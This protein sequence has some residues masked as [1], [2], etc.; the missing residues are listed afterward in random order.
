M[1][2]FDVF[3]CQNFLATALRKMTSSA[4]EDL[5]D[6]HNVV[7]GNLQHKRSRTGSIA[8][9]RNLVKDFAE[10]LGTGLYIHIGVCTSMI[11]HVDV[12][13]MGQQTS[14]LRLFASVQ[15]DR[16]ETSTVFAQLDNTQTQLTFDNDTDY[17]TPDGVPNRIALWR[18]CVLA[19]LICHRG[20]FLL[21]C[22]VSYPFR[23]RL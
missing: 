13:N 4:E 5:Q 3:G 8:L 21:N 19:C 22:F 9:S 10:L 16:A 17:P 12:C 14:S 2:V 11:L 7:H 23:F 6:L 1:F 20:E 15:L 18:V